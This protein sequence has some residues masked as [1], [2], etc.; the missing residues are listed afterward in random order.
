[1][2]SCVQ[3]P[4]CTRVHMHAEALFFRCL[5]PCGF[6]MGSLTVPARAGYSRP[7][8]SE[9]TLLSTLPRAKIT[10]MRHCT[11]LSHV[12]AGAQ[13][14]AFVLASAA[15]PPEPSPQPWRVYETANRETSCDT[16][17]VGCQ[18]VDAWF[19]VHSPFTQPTKTVWEAAARESLLAT[20]CCSVLELGRVLTSAL[21]H[22]LSSLLLGL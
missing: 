6:E 2:C 22:P 12:G 20:M 11:W 15:A 3:E 14:L 1:M 19:T 13:T 9:G 16:R 4:V 8:V 7:A 18:L 10:S 5:S 17:K 21:S